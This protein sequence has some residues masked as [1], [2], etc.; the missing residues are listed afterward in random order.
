MRLTTWIGCVP[1][2]V[3]IGAETKMEV[4]LFVTDQYEE[5]YASK[6]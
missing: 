6:N 1:A 2:G 4:D 3:P 5:K